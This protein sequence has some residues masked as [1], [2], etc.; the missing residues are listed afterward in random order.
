MGLLKRSMVIG[1]AYGLTVC[2]VEFW[3]GAL[4]IALL[5]IPVGLGLLSSA[6]LLEVG[7]GVALGVFAAPLAAV[8]KRPFLPALAIA[9]MWIA[10]ARAVAP[11]PALVP[12]WL[13][14]P[15][16]GLLLAGLGY[17]VARR[18]PRLA[19]CTGVLALVGAIAT[20]IVILRGQ[21]AEVAAPQVGIE[22]G[23]APRGAPDIVVVV[24]DTVRAANMST[25]GYARETTP[26]FTELAAEGALYLDA[27]SPSTWSLPSH[28]SLFT[29][30]F[31]SAHG[32]HG[33]H[34]VL[35]PQPPTL[36]DVLYRNGYDTLCF[37]ANP[38]ISDGFGLTRGFAWSDRAYLDGDGGRSFLFIYRVLDLFGVSVADKGGG[39]VADDF[40][41]WVDGRGE[42][43]RPSFVFLNFLEAHFP[44]HQVP[45]EFL[46]E[47]TK[48]SPY[49]LRNFSLQTFGAQFG[50]ELTE[51]EIG[52]AIAPT[53]DMYDAGVLYSDYL[54]GRVVDR[55]REAGSLDRTVLV[56]LSDHGE[57]LGEH[58]DF[59]HGASMHEPDL[60]VPLLV[61][62][63]PAV[64]AQTRVAAPVSTVGIYATVL[65]LVGLEPPGRVHV[66]SLLPM[67]KGEAGG[68]PIIAERYRN[69][70]LASGPGKGLSQ[71]V[72][73]RSYRSGR[74]KLVVTDTDESFLFDLVADPGEMRNLADEHPEDLRRLREE[75]ATWV[76]ALSL[77][78]LA[79]ELDVTNDAELDPATRERLKALGYVD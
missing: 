34:R 52:D 8:S 56:V 41:R 7:L 77:P 1:L 31:P 3:D 48:K 66:S 35:G 20:P 27:T 67:L 60:R 57:M 39:A 53:T 49:A 63:P 22:Q 40:E 38:H 73:F 71:N 29:G 15:A 11:D 17:A 14:A 55:L 50:R 79:A 74:F 43:D 26:T 2:I 45:R 25:Y 21:A 33:E 42:D 36:G 24:L 13:M 6:A 54:L 70:L 23:S 18:R 64:P 72:R 58:G 68:L 37:T 32:V 10:L 47:F 28:G 44:Y 69:D 65:D 12:M 19:W 61:R 46:A 75:L 59:G 5:R 30:W 4:R 9:L 76:E 78:A 51:D 16:A 62:Y